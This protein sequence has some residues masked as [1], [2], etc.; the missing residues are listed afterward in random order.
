MK[1][2][3]EEGEGLHQKEGAVVASAHWPMVE[4]EVEEDLRRQTVKK[5]KAGEHRRKTV[6]QE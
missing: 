2:G 6:G 5:A 1:E 3:G 4:E